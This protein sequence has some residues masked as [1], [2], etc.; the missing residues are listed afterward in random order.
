[1]KARNEHPCGCGTHMKSSWSTGICRPRVRVSIPCL[2][3]TNSGT[4]LHGASE[5]Y[6]SVKKHE[7]KP[8]KQ[9]LLSR[10]VPRPS[11]SICLA[12]YQR[13]YIFVGDVSELGV[14]RL[15]HDAP[16]RAW[17]C[18]DFYYLKRFIHFR[19]WQQF[20]HYSIHFFKGSYLYHKGFVFSCS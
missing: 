18:F 2:S 17:L 20:H 10:A 12:P 3:F 8:N 16:P 5:T 4:P 11:N 13:G 14:N 19:V 7:K 15:F 1:M 9:A 6:I